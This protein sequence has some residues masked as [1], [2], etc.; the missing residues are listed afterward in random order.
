MVDRSV[1]KLVVIMPLRKVVDELKPRALE[2]LKGVSPENAVGVA[3]I[4]K[5]LNI[6][7]TTAKILLL[8]LELEEKIGCIRTPRGNMYYG[9]VEPK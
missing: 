8:E 5:Q 2:I 3:E 6:A 1:L 9:R 7:W 4:A